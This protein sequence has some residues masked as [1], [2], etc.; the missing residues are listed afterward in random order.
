MNASGPTGTKI[1][2]TDVS[3]FPVEAASD[4]YEPVTLVLSGKSPALVTV[5]LQRHA[6]TR[7]PGR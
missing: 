3:D 5:K 1:D 6:T 2:G 4:R 7:R